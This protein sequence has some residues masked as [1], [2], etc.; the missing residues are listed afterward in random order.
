M[1]RAMETESDVATDD[2]IASLRAVVFASDAEGDATTTTES[3]TA[4]AIKNKE[5]AIERL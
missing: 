1:P 3:S 4:T 5:L 2:E